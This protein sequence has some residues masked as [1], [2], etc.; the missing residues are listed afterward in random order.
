MPELLK[1]LIF[2]CR[3]VSL[4]VIDVSGVDTRHI[5]FHSILVAE[6][7]ALIDDLHQ[8]SLT[9]QTEVRV[10]EHLCLT[11]W[12]GHELVIKADEVR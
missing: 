3:H 2:F 5:I 11:E 1:N 8:L 4:L 10:L 6:V 12:N 9:A 7:Q